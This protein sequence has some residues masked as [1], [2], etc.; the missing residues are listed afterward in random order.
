MAEITMTNRSA[1][2]YW[3]RKY[4]A[5]SKVDKKMFS[6]DELHGHGVH[7]KA[8]ERAVDAMD[9][10]DKYT[11]HDLIKNPKD[12]P[13]TYE[14]KDWFHEVLAQKANG[15]CC[16]V[17]AWEIRNP[18]ESPPY[19]LAWREVDD[20]TEIVELNRNNWRNRKYAKC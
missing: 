5:Y 10:V 3:Q 15:K 12:T 13:D 4:E 16:V 20:P 1:K 7:L 9:F 18:P 2:D 11:W 6:E 17:Q 8:L 19:Y 14:L